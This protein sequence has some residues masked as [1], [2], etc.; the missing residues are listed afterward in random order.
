MTIATAEEVVT[1]TAEEASAG[2]SDGGRRTNRSVD[3]HTYI[4]YVYVY[5]ILNKEKII[6]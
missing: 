6:F 5:V 3:I 4:Y 2:G 1:V